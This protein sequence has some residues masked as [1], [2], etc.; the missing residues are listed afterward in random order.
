[1]Q[2]T[3]VLQFLSYCSKNFS[4]SFK[5]IPILVQ[6]VALLFAYLSK[7]LPQMSC[8]LLA[9]M[10]TLRA[11]NQYS[12]TLFPLKRRYPESLQTANFLFVLAKEKYRKVPI[13]QLTD[14][15]QRVGERECFLVLNVAKIY[16]SF[17][18][19][20][21][22]YDMTATLDFITVSRLGR[23]EVASWWFLRQRIG[24]L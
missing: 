14:R 6:G 23:G 10:L 13:L 18:R 9:N 3:W 1:M 16:S 15:S 22:S 5:E 4:S 21:S 11:C 12:E 19:N 20:N 17:S 24:T 7:T 2:K 8:L